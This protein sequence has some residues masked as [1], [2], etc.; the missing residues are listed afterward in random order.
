M[1]TQDTIHPAADAQQVR[2]PSATLRSAADALE[3]AGPEL[4]EKFQQMVDG[5]QNRVTEWKGDIQSGIRAKPVQSVL[6]AVAVGAVLGLI[7]GRRG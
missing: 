6:I 2:K 4:K 1:T 5:G 7:V 3:T